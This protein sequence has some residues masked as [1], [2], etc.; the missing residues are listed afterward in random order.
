MCTNINNHVQIS[1]RLPPM[2][3]YF[4]FFLLISTSPSDVF[5]YTSITHTS[6]P[7]FMSTLK[8]CKRATFNTPVLVE[9]DD[10]SLINSLINI[11][12]ACVKIGCKFIVMVDSAD[13]ARIRSNIFYHILLILELCSNLCI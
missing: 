11:C 5:L 13:T 8:N 7:E 1:F 3:L 9:G 4:F 10:K 6:N 12:D 2:R